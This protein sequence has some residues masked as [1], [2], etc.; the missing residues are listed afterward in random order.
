MRCRSKSKL[1]LNEFVSKPSM[2]AVK[3][4]QA[5]VALNEFERVARVVAFRQSGS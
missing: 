2:M 1:F 5:D 4:H 3:D